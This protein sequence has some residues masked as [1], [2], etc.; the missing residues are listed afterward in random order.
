MCRAIANPAEIRLNWTLVRGSQLDWLA[1]VT[2]RTVDSQPAKWGK[3]SIVLA[4]LGK[5]DRAVVGSAIDIK[6]YQ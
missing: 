1:K 6:N 3:P 2:D 5:S 4:T